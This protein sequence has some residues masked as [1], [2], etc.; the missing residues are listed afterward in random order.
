MYNHNDCLALFTYFFSRDIYG[1]N[2]LKSELQ[3]KVHI[4]TILWLGAD[5]DCDNQLGKHGTQG[6]WVQG[7]QIVCHT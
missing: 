4:E 3:V 7:S 6:P 2:V 5:S 1:Q